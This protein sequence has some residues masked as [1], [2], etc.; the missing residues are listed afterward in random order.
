ML[1]V[2]SIASGSPQHTNKHFWGLPVC[3]LCPPCSVHISG[4]SVSP[5]RCGCFT[6]ELFLV[7]RPRQ[8]LS[9]LVVAVKEIEEIPAYLPSGAALKDA[10]QKAQ[11]WL[12]EVEALQVRQRSC[13]LLRGQRGLLSHPCCVLVPSAAPALQR[14]A[15]CSHGTVWVLGEQ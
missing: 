3:Y 4:C 7:P 5:R 12:Q 8:S 9:S 14:G 10:V 13:G 11:D 2:V 1:P 6:F 15:V